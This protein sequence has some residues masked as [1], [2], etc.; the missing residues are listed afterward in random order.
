MKL[1]IALCF[2]G[3]LFGAAPAY[4]SIKHNDDGGVAS[5]TISTGAQN[6]T[7]G[8][9]LVVG[10][11][12]VDPAFGVDSCAGAGSVAISNTAGDTFT[13]IGT[14]HLD[15]ATRVCSGMFYDA[16]TA[17]HASNDT[18]LTLGVSTFTKKSIMVM[19]ISGHDTT[20]LDVFDVKSNNDDVACGGNSCVVS[21]AFTTT[22]TDQILIGF[23]AS[24]S[25]FQTFTPDTGYTLAATVTDGLA[26]MQYKT[27]TS[28][29][30]SVTQTITVG[31][32]VGALHLWNISMKAPG[33]IPSRR[34]VVVSD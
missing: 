25:Y 5:A 14:L 21:D 16:S 28:V 12:W 23:A 24:Q 8:N 29:Q 7:A 6:H 2:A 4:V 22:T 15:A 11:M 20:P 1:L 33:G 10:V 32:S 3:C 17:G 26:A 13:Q 18:T 34:R 19:E 9:L 30:S 31:S 27:V